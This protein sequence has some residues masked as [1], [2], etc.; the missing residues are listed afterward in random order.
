MKPDLLKKK[1]QRKQE[2]FRDWDR[3]L[4]DCFDTT[5]FHLSLSDEQLKDEVIWSNGGT[6]YF[7]DSGTAM[8]ILIERDQPG[9]LTFM[10][11]DFIESQWGWNHR[12]ANLFS[13]FKQN[14]LDFSL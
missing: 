14:I 11:T 12:K 9:L 1:E 6:D 2:L 3:E 13:T 7:P 5:P 10:K 4:D 8:K